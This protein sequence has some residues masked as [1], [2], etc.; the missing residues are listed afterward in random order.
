MPALQN[1]NSETRDVEDDV[2][3]KVRTIMLAKTF[4]ELYIDVETVVLDGCAM[5]ATES[6]IFHNVTTI[7]ATRGDFVSLMKDVLAKHF[8]HPGIAF[9]ACAFLANCTSSLTMLCEMIRE[10]MAA[11]CK[12][13]L[14]RHIEDPAVVREV[15]KILRMYALPSNATKEEMGRDGYIQLLRRVMTT[16]H[17]R[18]D[19]MNAA[20]DFL[21]TLSFAESNRDQIVHGSFLTILRTASA[22][23]SPN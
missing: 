3:A 8:E 9:H 21:H 1:N 20:S 7:F 18:A 2:E 12:S 23:A 22:A 16:H 10:N 14:L 11:E 13:V 15:C 4:I 17:Q 6:Q 5:L 19:V